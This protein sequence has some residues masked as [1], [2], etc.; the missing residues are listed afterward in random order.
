MRL[1]LRGML[2]RMGARGGAVASG[3]PSAPASIAPAPDVSQALASAPAEPPPELPPP[4]PAPAPVRV[5]RRELCLA[6]LDP[7]ALRDLIA[8]LNARADEI[9]CV[10]FRPPGEHA[11]VTLI[12]AGNLERFFMLAAAR[13]LAGPV[14]YVQ[15]PVSYWYQG[16]PLLPDLDA[17]I[18]S[19]LVP[20][21]GAARALLFGQSSGGYAALAAATA[22]PGATVIACAPQTFADAA[23]KARIRFVGVRA[24]T[25]PEGILDLRARLAAHP[26]EASLRA[27]VIAAG[28][29]D[30]PAHAH[31]WGDYLHMLRLAD[32]P[33]MHLSVVNANTHVLAHNRVNQFALLLASVAGAITG[34]VG[35]R[36]ALLEEFLAVNYP[37][38]G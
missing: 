28:E 25:T 4:A 31:W 9:G 12:F 21:V 7:A 3:E 22:F 35:E 18:R 19:V 8:D 38:P 6:A 14:I 1:M 11:C 13:H 24:L 16:S 33:G 27:V 34:T 23:L 17:L 20:E 15:D 10:I 37:A 30:N 32:V 5:E 26:D 29:L 36:A 2:R